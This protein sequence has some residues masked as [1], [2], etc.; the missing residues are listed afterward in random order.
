MKEYTRNKISTWTL[1]K[2]R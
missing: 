2:D 1:R